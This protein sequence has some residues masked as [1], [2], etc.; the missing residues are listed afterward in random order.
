TA[1]ACL[2]A[3][4]W[5]VEPAA[6]HRAVIADAHRSRRGISRSARRW[7]ECES[8]RAEC[9]LFQP[10]CESRLSSY[11]LAPDPC[12]D[13]ETR[14]PHYDRPTE[15]AEKRTCSLNCLENRVV[16]ESLRFLR[17]RNF[18]RFQHYKDRRPPWIKLYRDLW[19]DPRFF[20]LSEENRYMLI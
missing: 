9:W 3:M 5:P 19:G 16:T 17:I 11:R 10:G 1:P 4:Y 6:G 14:N 20:A 15:P 18:E 2:C 12:G 7:A 13:P 8:S